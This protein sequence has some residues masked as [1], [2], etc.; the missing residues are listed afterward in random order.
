M[1]KMAI[2]DDSRQDIERLENL[3]KSN[4]KYHLIWDIF[5]CAEELLDVRYMLNMKYDI[6]VFDVEMPGI[7]GIELAR[8]IREEQP[9]A[10]FIFLTSFEKYAIPAFDVLALAYICKPI[11]VEKI[12]KMYEKFEPYLRNSH[13]EIL[14][15]YRK[16]YYRVML[17]N[18]IYIERANRLTKINLNEENDERKSLTINSKMD[19]L[20][21]KINSVSFGMP[22]TSYIINFQY[23]DMIK[24]DMV[25]MHNDIRIP[26]TRK[27][28]QE[29]MNRYIDFTKE[30]V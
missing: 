11:T 6:Y 9:T 29:F 14:F 25:Y 10:I 23:I 19:E 30:M 7:N 22:H 1:F 24:N 15:S 3:L 17:E 28:K 21:E 5:L 27:C 18:I 4:Q 12:E 2:C 13:R 20:M 26:I 8:I 16:D